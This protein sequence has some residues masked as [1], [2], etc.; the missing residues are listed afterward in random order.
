[1][2]RPAICGALALIAALAGTASATGTLRC[3]THVVDQG[4]SRD[5]VVAHCGQPAARKEGDRYWYYDRGSSMLL[6]RV[7]FVDDMV[8]FIDEVPR[9]EM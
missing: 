4:T 3:A 6:T 7:F 9:D 2:K 5:V 8:E 1:M